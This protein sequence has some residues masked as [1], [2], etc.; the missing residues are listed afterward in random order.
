[1]PKDDSAIEEALKQKAKDHSE[2]GFWKAYD[3][4]REEGITLK[5]IIH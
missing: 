2:E 1:L 4:L 3:R 5:L